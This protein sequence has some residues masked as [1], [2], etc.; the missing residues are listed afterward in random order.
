MEL[1]QA[2]NQWRDRPVDERFWNLQEGLAVAR[3]L[4]LRSTEGVFNTERIEFELIEDEPMLVTADEDG[5]RLP[6]R[7][8]NWAFGQVCRMLPAPASYLKKLPGGLAVECMNSGRDSMRGEVQLLNVVNGSYPTVRAVTSEKYTRVWNGELFEKLLELPPNWRVPPARPHVEDPRARP[9][10]EEDVLKLSQNSLSVKVGDMIAPAGVYVSD[11]D[12]FVFLVDDQNTVD[13]GTGHQLM[14]GMMFWNSEVGSRKIGGLCFLCD[15]VCGNHIVWGAKQS[16]EWGFKHTKNVENRAWEG[17]FGF[18]QEY[19]ETS[20]GDTELLIKKARTFEL[21]AT[22]DEV[23]ELLLAISAKR[24][25]PFS[26]K[27]LE[28]AYQTVEENPR[29]GSPRSA[30]GMLQGLTEVNQNT[31]HADTRTN[32]DII[33]GNLIYGLVK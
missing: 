9:A 11:R 12:M 8:S 2:H 4:Q 17:M 16:I 27:H 5:N 31:A 24:H 29:Y 15:T 30:W 21:A 18:V 32:L 23:L 13:D 25:Y 7:F 10:T 26:A 22:K 20:V 3:D 33:A 14:K 19:L 28:A 6:R 1:M